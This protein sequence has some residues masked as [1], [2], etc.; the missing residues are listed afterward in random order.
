VKLQTRL[1]GLLTDPRREWSIIAG[2]STDIASLYRDFILIVAAVPSVA[3]LLRLTLGGAPVLALRSAILGYLAAVASPMLAAMIIEKLAPKF[4]SSGSVIQ[5][6]KLVAYSSAPVWVAGAFYLLPGLGSVATLI[7]LLYA[8]YLFAL[9]LTPVLN[10]PRGQIVPF[11][12]VC[13]IVM[14]A[15]NIVLSFLFERA[16]Y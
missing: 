15:I 2:E 11:M 8:I 5:A 3:L 6:L 16:D 13:A 10:T 4:H 1:T 9:G 14:L 7:A 12:V